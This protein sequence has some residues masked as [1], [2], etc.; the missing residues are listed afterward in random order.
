MAAWCWFLDFAGVH[1]IVGVD[2]RID[3]H[4]AGFAAVHANENTGIAVDHLCREIERWS[5]AA[6]TVDN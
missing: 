5:V 3:V 6:V 2:H 1:I 4:I